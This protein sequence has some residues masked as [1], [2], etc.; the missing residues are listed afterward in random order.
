MRCVV[1]MAVVAKEERG[2]RRGRRRRRE[3]P[4]HTCVRKLGIELPIV[5]IVEI[6]ADKL[7]VRHEL[8]LVTLH[9]HVVC[10]SV[11]G[12]A[13]LGQLHARQVL[14]LSKRKPLAP[15]DLIESLTKRVT[16]VLIRHR[17]LARTIEKV[18]IAPQPKKIVLSDLGQRAP[19]ARCVGLLF[20]LLPAEARASIRQRPR[21]RLEHALK[22]EEECA[23]TIISTGRLR[24]MLQ[25]TTGS[26]RHFEEISSA[27]RRFTGERRT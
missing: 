15:A 16:Q 8:Q 27:A 6:E 17:V 25:D 1:K 2:R 19:G 13:H 14:L 22:S 26:T 20:A 23:S 3:K 12:N 18:L 10:H 11:F 7:L 21:C 24:S 4:R 5:G 9:R